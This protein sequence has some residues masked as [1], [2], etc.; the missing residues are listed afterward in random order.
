LRIWLDLTTRSHKEKARAAQQLGKTDEDEGRSHCLLTKEKRGHREKGNGKAELKAVQVE[1]VKLQRCFI[2]T[3]QKI[4]VI[5]EG[6]DAAV[7]EGTITRI[8]RHQKKRLKQRRDDPLSQW[9][10]SPH[11]RGGRKALAGL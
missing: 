6:L 1:L 5:I 7:K 8:V 10:I 9:K 3:G 2:E 4:L 11:R